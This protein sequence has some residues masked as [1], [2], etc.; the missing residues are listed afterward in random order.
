MS[1]P[2]VSVVIPSYNHAQYLAEAVASVRRQTHK[3]IEIIVVDD[4]ST[5]NTREL[6]KNIDGIR[7]LFQD[8]Q[9]LSSARN[10]GF[11]ASTGEYVVF[12][13]ADDYLYPEGIATNLAYLL[14][15]K[16]LAFVSGGHDKVDATGRVIPEE[17]GVVSERDHYVHLLQGNYIG[18]HATVMYSRWVLLLF[19]FDT[20]LKAC[21]DYDMYFRIT[22]HYPVMHHTKKVAAY[23]IHGANMSANIPFMLETVL[24]VHGAQEVLL[25][26]PV[27]KEAFQ[28]GRLIWKAYYA[29]RM[30]EMLSHEVARQ[31][32]PDESEIKKL[33]SI[34]PD[35]A[36]LL[37]KKIWRK[38]L[39]GKLKQLLPAAAIRIMHRV[40]FVRHFN[41]PLN[42][43]KWGDLERPRPLSTSFGYDR[44][45]PVDRYYIEG[46]LQ[47][48][49]NCIK[50]RTIEI[51]DNAYTLRFG[52]RSVTKSDV[53]H[54]YD[55]ND[56]VTF[57]GDLTDAPQIPS[58]AFDCVIL[59]QTLHLIYDFK[60][61]LATCYRILKPGGTL[62][63]TVPGISQIDN[64]EWK[65]YWLWAFTSASISRVLK[66][67]FPD[68]DIEV[69]SY[70]NVYIATAFLYG[71]GLPEVRK[72]YLGRH[73]PNYQVII[74]AKATKRPR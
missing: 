53:L 56:A 54:V 40:G 26:T 15:N 50:G 9:G 68:A 8:N 37:R 12:L 65:D 13:D 73:D 57:V 18:M 60:A 48:N 34:S 14:A 16:E 55:A 61:A 66:E 22:R 71:M 63:L 10:A 74:S 28:K 43:V 23:R 67:T 45:G 35:Y 72:D 39:K 41:P 38:R 47:E 30:Y 6:C 58:D 49:A 25:A 42:H 70:G 44:G 46:F 19:G 1:A 3:E 59:T 29:G 32:Y 11:A 20:S 24:A 33:G 51:G 52:N 21:E 2:L 17:P 69:K 7:Y 31:N 27:E 62:L 36:K 4:G 5:D 64:D